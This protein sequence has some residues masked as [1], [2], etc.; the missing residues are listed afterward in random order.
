MPEPSSVSCSLI[1]LDQTGWVKSPVPNRLMPFIL[2]H[3]SSRGNVVFLLQARAKRLWIWRSAMMRILTNGEKG[4][5][6][7]CERRVCA[8]LFR[9]F[10]EILLV[11]LPLLFLIFRF[12]VL[13]VVRFHPLH[14]FL[15][16]RGGVADTRSVADTEDDN[17]FSLFGALQAAFQGR[18]HLRKGV[19]DCLQI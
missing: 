19:C 4:I 5:N 17:A 10:S 6:R 9:F 1:S 15:C 16:G 18:L 11:Q 13:L 2:A 7:V 3:F 12:F 8:F 14:R